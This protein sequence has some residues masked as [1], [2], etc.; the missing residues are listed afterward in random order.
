MKIKQL[1]FAISE[2][3]L[4][5]RKNG[6]AAV[7]SLG[8]VMVSLL[9]MN[10]IFSITLVIR[11]NVSQLK[12]TAQVE[13]FCVPEATAEEISAIG[14]IIYGLDGVSG[15]TERSQ[16]DNYELYKEYL[17]DEAY[18]LDQYDS[19]IISA[20]FV[21]DLSDIS[22]GHDI[23]ETME[24]IQGVQSVQFPGQ[25]ARTISAVAT[26]LDVANVVIT[27]FLSVTSAFV[28]SNTIR[29]AL[30][31]R[32]REIGIMRLIG[33]T[34]KYIQMPFSAESILLAVAGALFALLMTAAAYTTLSNTLQANLAS[35]GVAVVQM[36]P[37]WRIMLVVAPL[38]IALSAFLGY[39][40]SKISLRKYLEV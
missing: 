28:I 5:I 9:I 40:G 32:K 15:V 8:I 12:Q 27:I 35:G 38:N 36:L 11:H 26:G 20:S 17:G 22:A 19:S 21:L 33:A 3:I 18:L 25:A 13:V 29:I 23:V 16:Q 31:T 2:G 39:F 7:M 4:N 1:F 34:D 30:M 6:L 14:S 37:L 10:L 24:Q